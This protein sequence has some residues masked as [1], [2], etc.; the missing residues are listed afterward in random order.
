MSI[1]VGIISE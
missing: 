1:E